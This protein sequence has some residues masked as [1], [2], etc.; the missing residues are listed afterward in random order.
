MPTDL[1]SQGRN[2]AQAVE[3]WLGRRRA[4]RAHLRALGQL[5]M[6]EGVIEP[7]IDARGACHAVPSDAEMGKRADD[8]FFQAED[9]LFDKVASLLQVDQRVSHD[10]PGAVVSDLATTVGLYNRNVAS[11]QQVAGQACQALRERGRVLANP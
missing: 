11:M 2:L 7:H 9:V 10:L 5:C 8:G 4:R 6:R 1:D 3:L